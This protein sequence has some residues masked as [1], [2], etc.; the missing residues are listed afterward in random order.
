MQL[1]WP[2]SDRH[3]WGPHDKSNNEEECVASLQTAL[4]GVDPCRARLV[5]VHRVRVSHTLDE[6]TLH[7]RHIVCYQPPLPCISHARLIHW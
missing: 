6:T 3:V 7:K 1:L 2:Q 4:G 5:E